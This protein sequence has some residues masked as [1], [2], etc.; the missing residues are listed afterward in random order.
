MIKNLPTEGIKRIRSSF[1]KSKYN[2]S[3]IFYRIIGK[4]LLA[5]SLH[6]RKEVEKE[7]LDYLQMVSSRISAQAYEA[8]KF[9]DILNEDILNDLVKFEE[10]LDKDL[11]NQISESASKNGYPLP[12]SAVS[13]MILN[14]LPTSLEDIRDFYCN[15]GKKVHNA[16]TSDMAMGYGNPNKSDERAIARSSF[17]L[18]DLIKGAVV[19]TIEERNPKPKRRY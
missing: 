15:L 18:E 12:G 14:N 7:E 6:F 10:E 17:S 5:S 13:T 19:R 8:Q 11:I 16:L 1:F 2:N 4:A 9:G 3:E